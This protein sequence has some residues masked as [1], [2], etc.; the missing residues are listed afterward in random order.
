MEP[1]ATRLTV[2]DG[3][4]AV[5]RSE[6]RDPT[7]TTPSAAKTART[8]TGYRSFD[9][10]RRC[11]QR[12]KAASSINERHVVAADLLR[13]WADG[14]CIGFSVPRELDQPVTMIRYGPTTGPGRT[15][16]RRTW[17]WRS[18]ARTMGIF[19]ANERRLLTFVVLLNRS[20]AA[21]CRERHEAKQH[22]NAARVM[23]TLVG[24][25]DRL[26]AF[27]DSEVQEALERGAAA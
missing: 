16:R 2:R 3:A 4:R 18:F 5:L 6:W 10:L 7:D 13:A 17:C 25:L 26:V 23:G 14:A 27:L 24:C 12:H 9:P 11:L 22:A 19:T 15:A 20:V 21:W 8:V 1:P